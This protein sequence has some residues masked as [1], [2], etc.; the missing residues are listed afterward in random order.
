MGVISDL[1][2][3]LTNDTFAS[4]AVAIV[5]G[6]AVVAVVTAL[7]SDLINPLIGLALHGNLD[8]ELVVVY[9]GSTFLFG[10][11]ISALINFVVVM[12]VIFFALVYPLAK[13]KERI[14]AR[15]ATASPTTR[16]CPECYSTINRKAKRCAFCGSEVTPLDP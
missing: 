11:F 15:K 16:E 4:M 14:D 9:G 5:V 2:A 8:A 1:K 12:V 13:R 10:T 7:I 3:F 6:L